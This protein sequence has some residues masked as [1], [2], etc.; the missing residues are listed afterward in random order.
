[1]PIGLPFTSVVT[2]TQFRLIG[3][4]VFVAE[5]ETLFAIPSGGAVG[6]SG[7]ALRFTGMPGVPVVP[8]I[9]SADG[10]DALLIASFT[11]FDVL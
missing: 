3:L 4:Q 11:L 10:V 2:L 7:A 9:P 8:A 5:V 1:M 6:A